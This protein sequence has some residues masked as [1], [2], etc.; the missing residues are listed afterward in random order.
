MLTRKRFLAVLFAAMTS[1]GVAQAASVDPVRVEG[2]PDTCGDQRFDSEATYDSEGNMIS[3]GIPIAG[4]CAMFSWL[5][6]SCDDPAVFG[7]V[8]VELCIELVDGNEMVSFKVTSGLATKV[9]VKGGPAANVYDYGSGIDED[10]GLYSPVNPGGNIADV[11]HVDFCLCYVPEDV[12]YESE[13]AW[14]AGT[15]YVARGNWATFTP[16]T[17]GTVTLFAGQ[18]FGAGTVTFSEPVDGQVTITIV[19]NDGFVF[20]STAESVKVQDYAAAPSGN[21][22]PGLFEHKDA[23]FDGAV[24]VIKVPENNF[25]GVHVDVLREVPCV[26]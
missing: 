1:F 3:P 14:G 5:A 10:R 19:L 7:L 24:A 6:P 22:A 9:V 4:E 17:V 2:N 16:Y 12:C 18:T 23:T 15:R 11:S 20:Q 8:T 21:P 13:T 25:Y 26:E